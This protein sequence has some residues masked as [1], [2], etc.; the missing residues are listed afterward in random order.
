MPAAKLRHGEALSDSDG[1]RV[2]VVRL[3]ERAAT[4]TVY[5]LTV[6]DA[7][8]YH[9]LAGSTP[10]LVHNCQVEY[11]GNDLSGRTAQ[12][13]LDNNIGA[14]NNIVAVRLKGGDVKFFTAT[15]GK[16]SEAYMDDFFAGKEHLV[17]EI[18]SER[19][20]CGRQTCM[21]TVTG[22]YGHAA[23]SWSFTGK[24]SI[25]R[26]MARNAVSLWQHGG[27]LF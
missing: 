1:N 2:M 27:T 20:P 15:R 14:D 3:S 6:N 8:T 10:V 23:L 26:T 21:P 11:G 25:T 24:V 12:Y 7:H 22:R 19:I 18:Y 17:D 9:V 16:H 5:N 13:R 4:T